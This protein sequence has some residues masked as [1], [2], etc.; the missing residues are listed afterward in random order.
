MNY[1]CDRRGGYGDSAEEAANLFSAPPT[2]NPWQVG[3]AQN[4][5]LS[6]AHHT[7]NINCNAAGMVEAAA[8]TGQGSIIF[9]GFLGG[10][11]YGGMQPTSTAALQARWTHAPT[12]L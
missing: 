11:G 2:R 8:G 9:Q 1:N 10:R 3:P 12:N 7:G 4:P 6:A 5:V